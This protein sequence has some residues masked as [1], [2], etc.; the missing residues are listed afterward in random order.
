M[1]QSIVAL[2]NIFRTL[3]LLALVGLLGTG[4]VI[5]Y[6]TW[7]AHEL[8]LAE[9]DRVLA[10]REEEIERLNEDLALKIEEIGRLETAMR[11][12]KVDH[13]LAQI[14]V[15]DQQPAEGDQPL[16]TTFRFVEVDRDGRPIEEPHDLTI[17][18][19]MLYVDAWVVK[20]Q[21]EHVES[22]DPLRSTSI[23]LFRRLFG[24]H[25]KPSEG[26]VLDAVGSRPTVY[27]D[28]MEMTPLE[29]EIWANF[30]EYANDQEKAEQ[31]GIRAAHGEAPSM[32][33]QPG[34]IYK[35][36]LRASDGLT[37]AVDDL[38]AALVVPSL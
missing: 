16:R 6:R 23:C 22:A 11:L 25:Q 12:L 10:E 18:G 20:Y 7:H 34:K 27:A 29:R 33:L 28:G 9:K 36:M 24:E 15:L 2:H 1:F 26:F 5:G 31:A 8:A 4:G 30:W 32:K 13:R 37:I 21:D 19:D 14:V 38:P 35:I 3:L 17:D